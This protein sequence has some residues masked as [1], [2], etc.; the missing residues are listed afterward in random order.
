MISNNENVITCKIADLITKIPVAGGMTPRCRN[1]LCNDV[2]SADIVIR[3]ALYRSNLYSTEMTESDVAY[4]ESARQFYYCLLNYNGLHLHASA[5]AVDGRA[6]LFSADPGV[7]KSTHA[8]LWQDMLKDRVEIINDDKPALRRLDGRWYAYG[9]P[10]C[11]K[12]GINL[13]RKVPVAGIC[14]LRQSGENKIRELNWIEAVSLI[15]P[16]TF[17]RLKSVDRM[18]ILLKRIEELVREIPVFELENRPEP[19]A[20]QLS[21]QTMQSKAKELGL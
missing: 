7:G 11:G 13:N 4:M 19:D 6:Y 16:Q 17:Y 15:L 20:A 14:F 18:D 10:W 3:D 2:A 8:R 1:Y 21:Y 9:T 12:D 5:V